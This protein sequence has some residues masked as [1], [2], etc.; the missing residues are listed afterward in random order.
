MKTMDHPNI[1][2][3]DWPHLLYTS[4]AI[5]LNFIAHTTASDWVA[6]TAILAS[7]LAAIYNSV[8]IYEWWEKRRSVRRYENRSTFKKPRT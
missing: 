4:F 5:I 8:K 2:T 3:Y 6:G 7:V 1:T